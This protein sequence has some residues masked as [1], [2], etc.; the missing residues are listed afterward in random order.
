MKKKPYIPTEEDIIAN[1]I[2][3]NLP[4]AVVEEI[5]SLKRDWDIGFIIS[6]YIRDYHTYDEYHLML[7]AVSKIFLTK[8]LIGKGLPKDDER[9]IKINKFL[10]DMGVSIQFHPHYGMI[11][12]DEIYDT[13]R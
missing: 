4:R 10:A 12:A 13:E 8:N 1:C 9:S 5:Y 7:K 11:I 2:V 3:Y 6:H